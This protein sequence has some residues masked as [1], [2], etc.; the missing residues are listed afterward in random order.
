MHKSINIPTIEIKVGRTKDVVLLEGLYVLREVGKLNY[1]RQ[2]TFEIVKTVEFDSD[3]PMGYRRFAS[4]N[5]VISITAHTR[6][7]SGELFGDPK[8]VEL[9]TFN[10][11]GD[12]IWSKELRGWNVASNRGGIHNINGDLLVCEME[13]GNSIL[14]LYNFK[15]GELI[16]EL[17]TAPLPNIAQSFGEKNDALVKGARIFLNQNGRFVCFSNNGGSL[18]ELILLEKEVYRGVVNNDK[19]FVTI[20]EGIDL[21]LKIIQIESLEVIKEQKLKFDFDFERMVVTDD[22]RYLVMNDTNKRFIACYDLELDELKWKREIASD[23]VSTQIRLIDQNTILYLAGNEGGAYGLLDIK[24]GEELARYLCEN[25]RSRPKFPMLFIEDQVFF[26]F[27]AFVSF[28]PKQKI[29][30]FG[31]V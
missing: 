29:L 8:F 26:N 1:V 23:I 12:L 2:D 28:I 16:D 17:V 13:N 30:Y 27:G 31:K 5:D 11:Q 10:S 24:T 14:S 4:N 6:V 7:V 20:I 18:T 22:A 25:E 3:H 21:I 19:L 15:S 9:K